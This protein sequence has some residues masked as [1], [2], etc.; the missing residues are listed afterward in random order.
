MSFLP[1]LAQKSA[2]QLSKSVIL[3][4]GIFDK[5]LKNGKLYFLLLC[6]KP[7]VLVCLDNSVPYEPFKD[8]I[9]L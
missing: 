5:Q 1:S 8:G 3:I 2:S 7:Y 9:V 6:S 4:N